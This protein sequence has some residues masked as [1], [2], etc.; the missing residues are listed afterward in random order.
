LIRNLIVGLKAQPTIIEEFIK[1]ICHPKL[2]GKCYFV[3][4]ILNLIQDLKYQKI[5]N[6]VRNDMHKK[7]GLVTTFTPAPAPAFTLAEVLITLGIIGVVAAM[8]IPN[9]IAGAQKNAVVTRLKEASSILNQAVRMYAY[10]TDD[11]GLDFD[12]TLSPQQFAEK[13]FKPYL[14]VARVCT[15][16]NEG[17]WKTG[18]FHGYYDLRGTKKTDTVPYS[19]VLNNG[20]VFGFGKINGYNLHSIVV[21]I[22]GNGGRNT[23]GKDI[24]VFYPYNKDGLCSGVD[25]KRAAMAKNGIY[26]GSFDNCGAPHQVYARDELLAPN[27]VLRACNKSADSQSGGRTGAGSACGALIMLDGWKISKDYPW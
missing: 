23:M 21:D 9:L 18:D 1:R 3:Y 12:I 26:I 25:A 15:R 11:D 22:N 13:Y 17:C 14:K 4:V 7:R 19:L 10:E 27:R 2:G 16:Q 8:T 20:M 24:F 5:P 6:Q